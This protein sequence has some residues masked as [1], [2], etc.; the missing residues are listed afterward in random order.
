MFF[1][2][3]LKLGPTYHFLPH[4]FMIIYIKVKKKTTL[5]LNSRVLQHLYKKKTLFPS[6]NSEIINTLW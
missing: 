3:R 1:F 2:Q 5:K 4:P 6:G